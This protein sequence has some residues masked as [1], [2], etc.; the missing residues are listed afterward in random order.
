MTRTKLISAAAL[1]IVVAFLA[2]GLQSPQW[3]S[4]RE[5]SGENA[6]PMPA[7]PHR[8]IWV[9]HS[10]VNA[11]DATIENA[12]NMIE[13]SETLG[14][15][16]G[17]EITNIDHT[18]FGASLSLLWR[19]SPHSYNRPEPEMAER[20]E[21]L[22]Q[23]DAADTIVLTEGIPVGLSEVREYT[24]YYLQ[25]FRCAFLEQNPEGR[26]YLYESWEHRQGS[27]PEAG[28][29][30]VDTFDW[31]A[32]A[33]ENRE[34]WDLLADLGSTGHVPSPGTRIE[35][36]FDAGVHCDSESPI[37]SIPVASVFAAIDD[38]ELRIGEAPL[39]SETLMLNPSE[40]WPESWPL[41]ESTG[42]GPSAEEV[43]A[44]P[45]RH[46]ER[47]RDDIH[48][49]NLGVYVA[50]LVSM[51]VLTQRSPEGL[52]GPSELREEERAALQRFVWQAVCDDARTGIPSCE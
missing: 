39:R 51:S 21:A 8:I 2:F 22:F 15:E 6:P 35:S 41:P 3:P 10:L 33:R 49:S 44:L 38:A 9:G 32:R 42:D 37:F 52:S 28:Y 12:Q 50:S 30:P 47:D 7:G 18:L 31:H 20:R 11:R 25:A 1:G 24:A 26:V 40:P 45:L 43:L 23:G 17:Y 46:P 13:W 19:G 27:D 29:G 36:Y 16:R 4:P 48:P 5:F 14:A 34:M